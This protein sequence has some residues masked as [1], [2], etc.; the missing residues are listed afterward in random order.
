[1]DHEAHTRD[2]IDLYDAEVRPL[3][4]EHPVVSIEALDQ[5]RA[6]LEQTLARSAG[7]SVG[8]IGASQVGKSSIIN[9]VLGQRVVPAG[10]L[11]P[12][13]AQAT[14]IAYRDVNTLEVKYHGREQLNRL[15]LGV[16][17][18][19]RKRNEL[20]NP[21]GA[22]ESSQDLD[23]LLDVELAQGETPPEE[24]A[25]RKTSSVGEHML[26][27]VRLMLQR[28]GDTAQQRTR[29]DELTRVALLDVVR[30]IL[31]QQLVDPQHSLD[32]VLRERAKEVRRLL[33]AN[34][35]IQ[36]AES[37]VSEFRRELR[38]RAAQWMSP[39]VAKLHLHLRLPV[40]SGLD[41][42]DLPGVGNVADAGA[43]I[44]SEFVGQT[45]SGALVVVFR[46]S[47]LT[48]DVIELL[49]R[50]GVFTRL[51]W[52]GREGQSPIRIIVAVTYVDSVAQNRYSEMLSE[53]GEAPPPEA[54]FATC[55]AEMTAHIQDGLR[56]ALEAS[57][58]Y[59]ES[60]GSLADREGAV[61]RA[62]AD[63][64]DVIVVDA[65]D[66]LEIKESQPKGRFLDDEDATNVPRLK[67]ML[68]DLAQ[69]SA[70]DRDE[71]IARAHEAFFES[72]SGAMRVLSS[73]YEQGGG[74]RTAQWERFRAGLADAA[75]PAH[76]AL[77][78]GR[79]HAGAALRVAVPTAIDDLC[80]AARENAHKKLRA[81][82][83]QGESLYWPSLNAAMRNGGT[84]EGKKLNYPGS[85]TRAMVDMIAAE[86][87]P[88]IVGGVRRVV[89]ELAASE[90]T[91]V[92]RVC[93]DARRID[94]SLVVDAQVDEQK[95]IL[96]QQ[97]RSCV[98]WT[99]ERL[100]ALREDIQAQLKDVVAK[101]IQSACDKT[102]AKGENRQAGASKRILDAFETGGS[103]AIDVAAER[104]L[105][106]MN[107]HYA[108]LVAELEGGYLHEHHDPV[109][110]AVAALSGDELTRA[111]DADQAA[112]RD[113]LA[114]SKKVADRLVT[115]APVTRRA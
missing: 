54:I 21:V 5:T 97:A 62:L 26:S 60:S 92:E 43:N 8:F 90:A 11:G 24:S 73:V 105:A 31:E 81:L 112:K 99:N 27:Q 95:R 23:A 56:R 88:T 42:V 91:L 67:Q 22:E 80:R 13:T 85:L 82:R 106:L 108:D 6:V 4:I 89:R 51:L 93:E 61:K 50:A 12:L 63:A 79:E 77:K 69:R 9:A 76:V 36:E 29:I 18:Y 7:L 102:M 87:E 115:A 64:I 16:E 94:A 74:R 39:L 44:A 47:G 70:A 65:K 98:K 14:R 100:E 72:A 41:L 17:S 113:V 40:L 78:T 32:D 34:E 55:A 3:L 86:W 30:T 103:A 35:S 111:R 38:L 19:L 57:R 59:Q 46:N 96:Q 1:M 104:A 58:A 48:T 52:G 66:F 25:G 68:L 15:R 37:G 10:G 114:K 20:T 28:P 33:G 83:K 71:A 101:P 110:A 84:W 45:T 49:D 107:R 2:L 109:T 53:H 75:R